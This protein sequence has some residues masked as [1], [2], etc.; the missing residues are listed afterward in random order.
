MMVS[1][2]KDPKY[3]YI[4]E[5]PF[6]PLAKYKKAVLCRIGNSK[7]T[8]FIPASYFVIFEGEILP[9]SGRDMTWVLQRQRKKINM[10]LNEMAD[11]LLERSKK[12]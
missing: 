10:Y 6:L 1:P 2:Y 9:I 4:N 5:I 3:F 12:N 11:R 8:I 7:Q